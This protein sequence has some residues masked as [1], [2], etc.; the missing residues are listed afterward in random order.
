MSTP[1]EPS[2]QPKRPERP[3]LACPPDYGSVIEYHSPDP[4]CRRRG[5][6]QRWCGDHVVVRPLSPRATPER[7]FDSAPWGAATTVI[8]REPPPLEQA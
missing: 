4:P 2:E 5:V 7:P 3:N 1:N 8:V 6:V